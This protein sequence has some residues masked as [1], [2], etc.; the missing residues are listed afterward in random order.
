MDFVQTFYNRQHPPAEKFGVKFYHF[1][2]IYRTNSKPSKG[3][4]H[5]R[6]PSSVAVVIW[7]QGGMPELI[8]LPVFPSAGLMRLKNSNVS[9][10]PAQVSN[11]HTLNVV[12]R[13]MLCFLVF[14]VIRRESYALI[15]ILQSKH[16]ACSDTHSGKFPA[17]LSSSWQIFL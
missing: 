7:W 8:V 16:S 10:V 4:N 12:E 11:Q 6:V 14:H 2:G 5:K 13:K 1:A 3:H 17:H 9:E 15:N